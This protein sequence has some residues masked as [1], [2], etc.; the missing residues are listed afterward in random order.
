MS[1]AYK[2]EF[3]PCNLNVLNLLNLISGSALSRGRRWPCLLG[4]LG[5]LGVLVPPRP[6]TFV[7]CHV[8]LLLCVIVVVIML[9]V[10]YELCVIV[11]CSML[12]HV[13]VIV[14]VLCDLYDCFAGASA[15]SQKWRSLG[16]AI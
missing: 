4:D 1:N 14:Y 9:C 6:H 15:T 11:V 3:V 2:T 16:R 7:I 8:V 10:C 12:C 13:V 5:G